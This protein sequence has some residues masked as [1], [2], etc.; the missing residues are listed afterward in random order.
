MTAEGLFLG[1]LVA[2]GLAALG[3]AWSGRGA[4]DPLEGR[5]R[6]LRRVDRS[7]ERDAD[8]IRRQARQALSGFMQPLLPHDQQHQER[9]RRRLILAGF[10]GPQALTGFYSA[11]MVLLLLPWILGLLLGACGLVPLPAGLLG[12]GAL[13]LVGWQ[14]PAWW[15]QRT[16]LKRQRRF[17]RVLP[18]LLDVLVICLE[19]GASLVTGFRRVGQAL[20]Q[21]YPFLG[22]ELII[23]D[24]ELQMGGTLGE[25][26]RHFAERTDLEELHTLSSVVAH[27]ERLGGS[28]ASALRVQADF[29]RQQGIQ[30]AEEKA[31]QAGVKVLFPTLLFLFPG[32]FVIL[33]G[34]AA[35]QVQEMLGR[36]RQPAEIGRTLPTMRPG[37]S[38]GR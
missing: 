8:R 38:H 34:P 35:L 31:H 33:L 13:S 19:G 10:Y 27:S 7:G 25:A 21:A 14:V 3:L 4:V 28:L 29:L 20:N 16:T 32:I 18:D 11:K 1:I 26:L 12:G 22:R 24:R 9:M 30:R 37:G 15:L 17:R 5:L 23:L 6:S 36:F 2:L